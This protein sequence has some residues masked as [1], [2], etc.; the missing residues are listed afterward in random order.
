VLSFA[1]IVCM[2]HLRLVGLKGKK[3]TPIVGWE[4]TVRSHRSTRWS[5]TEREC[6]TFTFGSSHLATVCMFLI[7]IK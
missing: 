2:D 6:G 7:F 4:V 3:I 1:G 5:S